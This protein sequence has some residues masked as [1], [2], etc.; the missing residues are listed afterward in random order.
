MSVM[1]PDSPHPVYRSRRANG[2][3]VFLSN[4]NLS[5]PQSTVPSEY[6]SCANSVNDVY[7][8][9]NDDVV[10]QRPQT[11]V[12]LTRV[13]RSHQE[14]SEASPSD[15]VV[16]S[17][18]P[19]LGGKMPTRSDRNSPKE[20]HSEFDHQTPSIEH[21]AQLQPETAS[22]GHEWVHRIRLILAVGLPVFIET[23]DYTVV[24]TSQIEIAVS[25]LDRLYTLKLIICIVLLQRFKYAEVCVTLMFRGQ[26]PKS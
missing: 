16:N 19:W 14:H 26:S 15:V 20:E 2:S 4:S 17:M 13:H 5:R 21:T 24:A 9:A 18:E 22:D 1:K 6:H 12:P 3:E 8:D 11:P 23:M 7:Y 25:A 10:T